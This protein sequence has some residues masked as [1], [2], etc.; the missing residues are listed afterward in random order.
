MTIEAALKAFLT[1][2]PYPLALGAR[3]YMHKAPQNA[4][5]PYAVVYL[6]AT[7]P[8]SAHTGR[9]GARREQ[10]QVSVFGKSHEVTRGIGMS[11]QTMVDGYRGP[12]GDLYVT[13]LFAGGR[14]TFN[15]ATA[16]HQYAVDFQFSYK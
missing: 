1:G 5:D 6:I 12:M 11:L 13:A 14:M 9:P 8:L 3:V 2:S 7:T 15:E 16:V 10:L 4:G